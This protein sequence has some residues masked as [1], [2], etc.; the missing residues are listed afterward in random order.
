MGL[1]RGLGMGSLRAVVVELL[2]FLEPAN[3]VVHAGQDV[4]VVGA[5]MVEPEGL[6]LREERWG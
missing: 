2:V 4:A 3:L 1:V 5:D 6:E